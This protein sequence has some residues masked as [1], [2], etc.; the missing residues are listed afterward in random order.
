MNGDPAHDAHHAARAADVL[1]AGGIVA[2]P[3]ETVYGLAANALDPAAIAKI[4]EAKGRPSTNPLIVH[5]T[6][7]E[8]AKALASAWPVAAQKLAEACWPGPLTL[9]VPK[10][11]VVPDGATAGLPNVAL[12]VPSHPVMRAVIDAAGLPLAAPS[13]NRSQA[14]SPTRAAHVLKSLGD[15]VDLI[16]DAGTTEHGLE[17]TVVDCTVVPPRVLRPGPVTI[18]AL[19]RVLG[20]VKSDQSDVADALARPS[21]GMSPKHYSP[22]ANVVLA[23]AAKLAEAVASAEAPVGAFVLASALLNP[24]ATVTQMPADPV[25]YGAILY[26]E[27]H[28]MDDLGVKTLVV[29]EPPPVPGWEAVRDRL[30][31]ASA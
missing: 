10:N 23:P 12:R 31:R 2:L 15:R 27:L 14:V 30:R 3:T 13:A 17:S 18:A 21:P 25:A 9:V 20:R 16:L 24:T 8:A 22:Q 1:R 28:R 4:Y 19:E 11:P 7:L 29:E 26:T 5:V 6:S